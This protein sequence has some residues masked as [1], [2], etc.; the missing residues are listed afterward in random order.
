MLSEWYCGAASH[1]SALVIIYHGHIV[2][3]MWVVIVVVV[4]APPHPN[5]CSLGP[6]VGELTLYDLLK[7][8][9]SAYFR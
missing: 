6:G 4:L 2:A 8:F 1:S 7:T 5:S 3:D 9:E